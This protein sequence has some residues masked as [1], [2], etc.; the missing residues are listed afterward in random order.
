MPVAVLILSGGGQRLGRWRLIAGAAPLLI[1]GWWYA[2]N[3]LTTGNP[4]RP[5][6]IGRA[7][8]RPTRAAVLRL[9]PSVPWLRTIDAIL[10][11]HI[12]C[13]GWSWL[14]VRSWMYHL[15]YAVLALAAIG[16]WRW[17]RQPG[18]LW[19]LAIYLFFWAGELWH[20]ALLFATHGV[21]ASMGWYLYGVVAAE[22][23]LS[24]A[25]LSTW[26][27]RW[28]APAGAGLFALLDLLA[29]HLLALP[30]YAGLIRHRPDGTLHLAHAGSLN[31]PLIFERLSTLVAEPVW[32]VLWV[33]YL[34]A[35]IAAVLLAVR[36]GASG[37]T[38]AP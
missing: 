18:I 4:G 33:G 10:F 28:A 36:S 37:T 19:L 27:R 16:L 25:G 22:V 38:A 14:T 1:A 29:M 34:L 3:L 15:F 2:R 8:R 24:V 5:G 6:R 26:I 11:S 9:A 7:C 17:L 30:Y 13:G 21:P 32:I 20:A 23:P 12:Y 31:L 35:T